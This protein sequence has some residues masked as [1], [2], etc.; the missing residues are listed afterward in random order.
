MEVFLC[1]DNSTDGTGQM[2]RNHFPQVNLTTGTGDLYWGGGMRMAWQLANNH[3]SFDFFL[4]LN[5]DTILY[6]NALLKLWE[7][8]SMIPENTAI[9]LGACAIPGTKKFSYGGH[10]MSLRPI[11]PNGTLQKVTYMNGNL[12]LIPA[13]I[14]KKLGMI[15][16]EYTHY[17]GDY[18][19]SMRAQEA[20]FSCYSS[21]TFLAECNVN[22]L[23]Y[24]ADPLLSFRTRWQ[25]AHSV[26]G[27]ALEEY[28]YF[29]SYHW[30]K[31]IG[32]KSRI[33]VYLK[34]VFPH[35]YV[36]LRK[37]LS[38]KKAIGFMFGF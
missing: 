4:W 10:N 29:K 12:V 34:L 7:E 6:P 23:P 1:D 30:G 13:E 38:G 11:L 32:F 21:S 19:Y 2:V 36:E 20:G 24:W 33:E 28:V 16:Q 17:L 5:D 8:Y 3:G 14:E 37:F 15:S 31:W 26:K 25:L 27:L 9:L 18:D 35:Y 22:E